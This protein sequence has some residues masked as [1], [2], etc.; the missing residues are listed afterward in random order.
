MLVEEVLA[1]EEDSKGEGEGVD[2]VTAGW[3]FE[4]LRGLAHK[5]YTAAVP[6]IS[7]AESVGGNDTLPRC[8]W[9][10]IGAP[11]HVLARPE[12]VFASR[13]PLAI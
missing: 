3:A 8:H 7:E 12:R 13:P 5:T 9:P 2:G 11:W 1:A 10:P 6:G 4:R